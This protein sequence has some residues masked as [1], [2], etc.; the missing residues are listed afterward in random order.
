MTAT[1]PASP[2]DSASAEIRNPAPLGWPWTNTNGVTDDL[3]ARVEQLPC[4]C[5]SRVDDEKVLCAMHL[6][7]INSRCSFQPEDWGDWCGVDGPVMLCNTHGLPGIGV[8][9][10]APGEA[11][12]TCQPADA[13]TASA[14]P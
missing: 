10:F 3:E 4:G 6:D 7:A 8:Y 5:Y 2:N 12:G 1:A 9:E 14:Q 13:E 11:I